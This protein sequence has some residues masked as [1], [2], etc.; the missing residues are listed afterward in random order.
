MP[1]HGDRA[2]TNDTMLQQQSCVEFTFSTAP[3]SAY[4][5]LGD[6]HDCMKRSHTR[7]Q[8][9]GAVPNVSIKR[10]LFA[11]LGGVFFGIGVIGAFLPVLPTTP[12]MLLALWAFSNSSQKLHD[13]IWFHPTY[14]PLIR[15]WKEHGAV[16]FK[17]KISALAVMSASAIFI[18]FFSG[19]PLYAIAPGLALMAVG[20]TFMLTR[21][22]LRHG[23]LDDQP[24]SP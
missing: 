16:P 19:A 12:F 15:A 5:T 13:Y 1:S 23:E 4:S 17:A 2:H 22:T 8:I 11:L 14:G 10:S 6:Q 7:N 24:S 21:P 18:I 9:E 20:A 3:W